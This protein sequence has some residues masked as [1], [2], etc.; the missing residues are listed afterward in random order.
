MNTG[1]R[2]S[3][4]GRGRRS[5]L[6]AKESGDATVRDGDYLEHPNTATINPRVSLRQRRQAVTCRLHDQRGREVV[7]ASNEPDR[8]VRGDFQR[9]AC[10][11]CNP[12][13]ARRYHA[14]T[15]SERCS[16]PQVFF[17]MAGLLSRNLRTMGLRIDAI[18]QSRAVSRRQ[19]IAS[20]RQ[21]A[22]LRKRASG[23]PTN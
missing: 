5:Y 15:V 8:N 14:Q 4:P 12:S 23:N 11:R 17:L 22:V 16:S 19:V 7:G 9:R 21:A 10:R 13:L 1:C 2:A 3:V 18:L 6:I 20:I